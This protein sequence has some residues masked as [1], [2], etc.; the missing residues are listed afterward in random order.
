MTAP[1]SRTVAVIQARMSSSRFP[2]K[3]L[4]PL[5]GLPMIVFMARRAR[6]ARLLDAV[7]VATSS[8]T[9]DDALAEALTAS[10]VTVFRGNLADVLGRFLEAAR[11]EQATE[12]VRLTGDCPLIDPEVIDQVVAARRTTGADYSSNIDPP[13]FPDGLDVECFTREAL[14]LAGRQAVKLAEREHV[15]LWMRGPAAPLRRTNVIA[16]ADCSAIRL[17][18]DYPDD[19]VAVRRIVDGAG[20]HGEFDF[21][22]ILRAI[23]RDPSILGL[24]QHDRNEGLKAS[25]AADPESGQSET[26]PT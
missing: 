10:G 2:G 25:L 14:D 21:Y 20:T 11:A 23:S 3:V 4:E 8:D 18:V 19:L 26:G 16:P 15:T 13:T 24:N 7:V 22:D 1:I 6:R 17:T 12:I 9:S 5:A